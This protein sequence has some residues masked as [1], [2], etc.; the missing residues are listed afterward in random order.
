MS[1][2]LPRSVEMRKSVARFR[3][4]SGYFSDQPTHVGAEAELAAI[5]AIDQHRHAAVVGAM[6]CGCRFELHWRFNFNWFPLDGRL[7]APT[8]KQFLRFGLVGAFG[9]FVDAGILYAAMAWLDFGLYGGRVVSFAG[10]ATFTWAANRAYAFRHAPPSPPLRQWLRFLAANSAGA[11]A[12]F[13]MYSLVVSSSEFGA[14]HPILGIALG[15]IAGLAFNFS[16]SRAWVF[17]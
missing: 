17:R 5:P 7:L 2:M 8:S 10:A 16:A 12:N 15:S 11:A 4:A 13:G 3:P 14:S 6:S 9:F 1:A